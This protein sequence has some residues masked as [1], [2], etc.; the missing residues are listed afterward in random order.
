MENDTAADIPQAL[1]M[2]MRDH[3][4]VRKLADTWL[5]SDDQ[6]V[7]QQAAEQ[8]VL[9]VETHSKLEEAV[10]YPAVR[11][12]DPELVVRFENVHGD[13]DDLIATLKTT[14]LTGE[15]AEAM[16]DELITAVMRHIE[17]EQ[18]QLF[19]HIARAVNLDLDAIANE[20]EMFEANFVHQQTQTGQQGAWR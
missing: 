6:K 11:T 3:N 8:F 18:S 16:L 7:R 14:P 2:L 5:Y 20:M 4:Y 13:A 19:P 15:R 1:V 12:L 10:F 17:Q 9:A